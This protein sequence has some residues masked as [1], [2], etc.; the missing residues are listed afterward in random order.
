M[1]RQ[2]DRR[3]V[4]I[5]KR[6]KALATILLTDRDDLLIEEVS[7]EIGLDYIVRFRTTGKEGLREFGVS[8]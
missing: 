5:Q 8:V 2:E 6:A 7:N 4:F 3:E 1:S